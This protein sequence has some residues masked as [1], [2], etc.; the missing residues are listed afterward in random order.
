MK[1]IQVRVYGRVQGV[2]F[3]VWCKEQALAK[4]LVGLVRN[5]ENGSVYIELEGDFK[6]VQSVVEACYFGP[7]LAVVTDVATKEISLKKDNEFEIHD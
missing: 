5:E 7:E 6:A 2:S 1:R 4:K 3:R